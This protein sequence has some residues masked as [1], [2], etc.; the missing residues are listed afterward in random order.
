MDNKIK[1]YIADNTEF[2]D[3]LIKNLNQNE[4]TI[5]GNTNDG[6]IAINEII[7]LCPDVVIFDIVLPFGYKY[8]DTKVIDMVKE[9]ISAIENFDY[10]AVVKV[11]HSYV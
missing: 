6:Q 5:V 9:N 2:K 3:E 1:I 10:R 4:I 11:D 7:T 8:S